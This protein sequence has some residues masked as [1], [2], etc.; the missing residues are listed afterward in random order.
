MPGCCQTGGRRHR[1]RDRVRC[2]VQETTC[3]VGRS[4]DGD[5][6][7][8]VAVCRRSCRQFSDAHIILLRGMGLRNRGRVTGSRRVCGSARR[9]RPSGR[10][11]RV[12]V[13]CVLS[14]VFSRPSSTCG[15]PASGFAEA[16]KKGT[17]TP[18]F[19]SPFFSRFCH[20]DWSGSRTTPAK[21]AAGGGPLAHAA[22][23]E[24]LAIARPPVTRPGTRVACRTRIG[25]GRPSTTTS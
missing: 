3:P 18:P 22:K 11:G 12:R 19:C 9:V 14:G 16:S 6:I 25:C 21:H 4:A 1:L 13:S 5:M 23:S 2:E 8:S 10:A 7:L 15:P 24:P 20:I 17:G